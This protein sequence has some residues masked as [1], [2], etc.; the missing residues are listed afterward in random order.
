MQ[1]LPKSIR[2]R[3]VGKI[4]FFVH[5]FMDSSQLEYERFDAR[6]FHDAIFMNHRQYES[7]AMLIEFAAYHQLKRRDTP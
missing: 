6:S 7:P 2:Q 1:R 3:G 5:D 4:S